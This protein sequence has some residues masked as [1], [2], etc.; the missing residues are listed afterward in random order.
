MCADNVSKGGRT[1]SS[2]NLPS[3][4]AGGTIKP[5]HINSLAAAMEKFAIQP[6]VGVRLTRTP[7]GSTLRIDE[8]TR[9]HHPWQV[10]VRA[11]Y[12]HIIIGR[13]FYNSGS[14]GG[15]KNGRN[16]WMA[17]QSYAHA[18][19][20]KY[21]ADPK[22]TDGEFGAGAEVF[23]DLQ[24]SN[25]ISTMG[26]KSGKVPLIVKSKEGFYY[27]DVSAWSGRQLLRQNAPHLTEAEGVAI[28]DYSKG[29]TGAR[30]PVIKWASFEDARKIKSL[31]YPI[32]SVDKYGNIFQGV[33]SDIYHIVAD[34]ECPFTVS[35]TSPQASN[36]SSTSSKYVAIQMGVV[37]KIIPKIANKYIDEP[38]VY[39]NVT[40]A[41]GF[42][43]VEATYEPSSDPAT[44]K[45]FPTK[46]EIGFVSGDELHKDTNTKG[47]FPLARIRNTTVDPGG[48]GDV[49]ATYANDHS[50]AQIVCGNLVVNRL[51]A[52]ANTA[53]WWWDI[54]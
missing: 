46:I 38:D 6:S 42:V 49:P 21:N 12:L 27:I 26:I 50:I 18:S 37:N 14:A 17:N 25:Y 34:D 22:T 15:V 54:L 45:Y 28:N 13:F 43:F 44:N 16:G 40:N 20:Y 23:C 35:F 48:P 53:V 39:L 9:H 3:A 1:P 11:G 41:P 32:C 30:V 5:T 47:Y 33:R 4:N 29:R 24:G 8:R 52:G 7:S 51:K 10:Y 36:P 19:G 31:V 2:L